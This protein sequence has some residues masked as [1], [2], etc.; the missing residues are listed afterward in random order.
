MLYLPNF[1]VKFFCRT[2]KKECHGMERGYGTYQGPI[3]CICPYNNQN[4]KTTM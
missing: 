4:T 2:K 1:V 3:L